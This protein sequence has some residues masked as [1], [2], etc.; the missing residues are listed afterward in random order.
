MKF[1]NNG[2]TLIE[3]LAVIVILAII[4]LIATP[5]VLNIIKDTKNS[6]TERSAELYLSQVTDEIVRYNMTHPGATFNPTECVL[7]SNGLKCDGIEEVITVSVTGQTPEIGSTIL[8]SNGSV[9]GLKNF[10]MDS[11][12]LIY[13]NGKVKEGEEN[14]SKPICTKVTVATTGNVPSGNFE[15]GD[16]YTCDV[17]DGELK[18]FFVLA[19]TDTDVSLIMNKNLGTDV[20]WSE[21]N[22]NHKS[23]DESY[24]ATVAKAAL[25]EY[26]AGWT[27]LTQAQVA[28]PTGQQIADA[29]GSSYTSSDEFSKII[30]LDWLIGENY[31]TSTPVTGKSP[32][33]TNSAWCVIDNRLFTEFV[34]Q[35]LGI[36]AVIT[37][38]KSNIS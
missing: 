15:Y 21:D 5:V 23:E 16:E 7:Q 33:S 13:D 8:L 12:N 31:W 9:V 4:A 32:T 24:H 2:F 37:I 34:N 26:T 19:K 25:K 36:R 11:K 28:L 30:S 22:S 14:V 35:T 1:K 17:G 38:P 20:T 18:T 29:I 6:S 10:K 3:L 27:K